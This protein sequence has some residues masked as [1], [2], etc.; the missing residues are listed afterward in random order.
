MD[1]TILRLSLAVIFTGKLAVLG[2]R[3]VSFDYCGFLGDIRW[4][5]QFGEDY[6][7]KKGRASWIFDLQKANCVFFAT[8]GF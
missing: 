4:Q 5:S 6:H 2:V 3:E 1:Q 7:F 8:M